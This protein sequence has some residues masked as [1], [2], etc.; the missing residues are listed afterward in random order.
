MKMSGSNEVFVRFR[1]D[2]KK[3][4]LNIQ[5]QYED[6]HFRFS[7][8]FDKDSREFEENKIHPKTLSQLSFTDDS[9]IS[10]EISWPNLSHWQSYHFFENQSLP[11]YFLQMS[12]ERTQNHYQIVI[13]VETSRIALFK[14]G[15]I[16]QWIMKTDTDSLSDQKELIKQLVQFCKVHTNLMGLRVQPYM[17]GSTSLDF[18]Q[19]LLNQFG[20]IEAGPMANVKTRMIDLR[21]PVEE[22]LSS[23]SANGRARLKIKPKAQEV[24]EVKEINSLM[25]IPFLQDALNASFNRSI[26]KECPYNF[27]P[28]FKRLTQFPSEVVMLGFYFKEHHSRPMAFVTG[29]GHGNIVE[30]SVGGSLSDTRLRQFPFNHILMWQLALRSKDNGVEFLDLGGISNGDDDDALM[31]I[32]NFKRFFPGFELSTGR[33]ME[34]ELRP[35]YIYFYT[36]FQNLVRCLDWIKTCTLFFVRLTNYKEFICRQHI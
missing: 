19:Q 30:Y 10:R 34:V 13:R 1:N 9:N 18:A 2:E 15:I 4:I 31:G 28:L 7:N 14:K 17:P 23:F 6:Y 33:E 27:H 21:P 8:S 16:Q 24:I 3:D 32:T 35:R 11:Y 5:F 25:E 26:K 12:N 22:I 36:K 20:F 29:I